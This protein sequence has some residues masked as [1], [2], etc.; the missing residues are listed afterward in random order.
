MEDVV[1]SIW[2]PLDARGHRPVGLRRADH[3]EDVLGVV[4][5]GD[6]VGGE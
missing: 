1:F 6:E 2:L 3:L 5:G 4:A